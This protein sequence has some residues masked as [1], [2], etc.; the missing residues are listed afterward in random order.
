MIDI[1]DNLMGQRNHK[2]KIKSKK[3]SDKHGEKIG[4]AY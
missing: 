2:S 1:L 4:M 3:I